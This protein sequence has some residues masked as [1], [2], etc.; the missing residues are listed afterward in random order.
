M[1]EYEQLR[2][3]AEGAGVSLREAV[4][5]FVRGR[6]AVGEAV[7]LGDAV[8]GFVASREGL[9]RS[10]RYVRQLGVS[11]GGFVRVCGSEVK[12]AALGTAEVR[13]WLAA[14]GW[15][16]VTQRGYLGDLRAFFAWARKQGWLGANPSEGVEVA[17][18]PEGEIQTLGVG[19]VE[20]LLR[21]ALGSG[22]AELLWYAVLATFCG[23]RPA[24][25]ERL[26]LDR[27]NLEERTV[28]ITGGTAKTARRRVVDLPENAV[29]W[30]RMLEKQKAES[31]K[32]KVCGAGWE[33]R[34]LCLR[35]AAGWSVGLKRKREVAGWYKV[36][37]CALTQGP[38]PHD[39]LRHTYAS[40]H[41]AHFQ[42]EALLKAQMGHWERADTLHRHYRALRTRVEAER[43]WNLW[44]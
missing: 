13:A 31:G 39:V 1:L 37:D 19:Q 29:A 30:L 28:I 4:E 32:Q 36:R 40:M 33:D 7:G 11:L 34:W 41:Y 3:L 10:E 15:S 43:F 44:P 14:E 24:E 25:I 5:G 17:G 12:L 6:G 26:T 38:W 2:E 9:N 20:V 35:R 21:A 16:V 8:R 18:V 27:I 42:N 22:D 23:I